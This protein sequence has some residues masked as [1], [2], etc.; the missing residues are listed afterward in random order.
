MASQLISWYCSFHHLHILEFH[1]R[2]LFEAYILFQNSLLLLAHVCKL[3]VGPE[4]IVLL[5]LYLTV[6]IAALIWDD[7]SKNLYPLTSIW[8]TL[9]SIPYSRES[10]KLLDLRPQL[11]ST[12]L[13]QRTK[14]LGTHRL[15]HFA[16]SERNYV[17]VWRIWCFMH[18]WYSQ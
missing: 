8:L 2:N 15:C 14:C 12:S 6:G 7:R 4:T 9:T 13:Q 3:R 1:I 10:G 16:Y 18:V 17:G 11:S 5:S